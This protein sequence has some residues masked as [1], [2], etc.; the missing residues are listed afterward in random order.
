MYKVLSSGLTLVLPV[1]CQGHRK[2]IGIGR[3]NAVGARGRTVSACSMI[4]RYANTIFCAKLT[5]KVK[6]F[7]SWV[8]WAGGS[9]VAS[10]SD[11]A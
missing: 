8:K 1:K 6:V 9:E 10:H 5:I 4:S 11:H 2:Q 7:N 3:A